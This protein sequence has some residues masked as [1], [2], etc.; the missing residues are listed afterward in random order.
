MGS[1]QTVAL[2]EH[3][4]EVVL[5]ARPYKVKVIHLPRMQRSPKLTIRIWDAKTGAVVGQ[6]LEGHATS[7]KWSGKEAIWHLR[8]EFRH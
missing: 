5:H 7:P 4:Q 6:P 2:Q 3:P 8:V 1:Y